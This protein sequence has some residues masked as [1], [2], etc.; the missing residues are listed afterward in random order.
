MLLRKMVLLIMIIWWEEMNRLTFSLFPP[1]FPHPA[2][3]LTNNVT[4]YESG[5]KTDRVLHVMM[6]ESVFFCGW[7]AEAFM[8][9]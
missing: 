6:V 7:N 2:F 3:V 5:E 9:F 8:Y 4:N 1:T